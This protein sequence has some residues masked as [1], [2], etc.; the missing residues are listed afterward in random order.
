[1]PIRSEKLVAGIAGTALLLLGWGAHQLYSLNREVGVMQQRLN[2][3]EDALK[4]LNGKL[5]GKMDQ[6]LEILRNQKGK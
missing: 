2:L 5:D 1:M 3:T 4:V 6:V